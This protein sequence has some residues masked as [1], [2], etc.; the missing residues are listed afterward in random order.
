[1]PWSTENDHLL[2]CSFCY[3]YWRKKVLSSEILKEQWLVVM[4][5]LQIPRNQIHSCGLCK[6]Q[7]FF[8]SLKV[9]FNSSLLFSIRLKQQI[10]SAQNCW[11]ILRSHSSSGMDMFKWLQKPEHNYYEMMQASRYHWHDGP[12]Q[13]LNPS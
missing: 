8:H 7:T 11:Y 12:L 1:V 2:P 9:Y 10:F 5:R 4:S 3:P 13:K 6:T